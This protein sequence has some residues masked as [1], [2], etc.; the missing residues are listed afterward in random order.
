[1]ERVFANQQRPTA[2]YEKKLQADLVKQD[3]NLTVLA[4]E[5]MRRTR[6]LSLPRGW[7]NSGPMPQKRKRRFETLLL[8]EKERNR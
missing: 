4:V 8:I 6:L 1:M 5:Q 2:A 3:P 7:A